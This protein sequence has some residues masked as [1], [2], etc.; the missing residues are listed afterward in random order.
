MKYDEFIKVVQD[1]GH[2]DSREE[3]E[4]ATRATLEALAE[5]LAGGEPHD[6]ASQLPPELAQHLRYEG[7]ET[8]N[9]FS[10]DEFFERVNEKDEDVDLPK[11]AYHARVVIGVLQDAVTGG[12]IAH[13]RSQL[14]EEYS[15]LFEAG[16]QGKMST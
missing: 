8:S 10:L 7:E 3:A 5:R 1:R 16:S 13:I 14:P 11:A 2:M 15:P 6:L 12:E 9:P 4:K